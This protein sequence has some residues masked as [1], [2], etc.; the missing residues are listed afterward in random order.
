VIKKNRNVFTS[1][2]GKVDNGGSFKLSSLYKE[3]KF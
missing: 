2:F 3:L 1:K